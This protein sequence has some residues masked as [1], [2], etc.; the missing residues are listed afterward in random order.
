MSNLTDHEHAL[1]LQVDEAL[2]NL[3]R[4]LKAVE[5]AN[6]QITFALHNAAIT[7]FTVR[8]STEIVWGI[9]GQSK[10]AGKTT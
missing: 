2:V 7:E 3:C 9:P 1:V 4:A 8:K 6:I 5:L 10:P